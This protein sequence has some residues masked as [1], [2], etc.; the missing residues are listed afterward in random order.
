MAADSQQSISN[1]YVPISVFADGPLFLSPEEHPNGTWSEQHGNYNQWWAAYK[2]YNLNRKAGNVLVYPFKLNLVRPAVHI[3]AA[4][5]LGQYDENRIVK[6]GISNDIENETTRR[7]TTDLINLL[8]RI[9]NGDPTLVEQS[10]FQ[11]IFGGFFYHQVWAP[12]NKAM[13][14]RFY[15]LDPRA[16]FPVWDGYDYNRIISVDIMQQIPKSVA[17]S[18]YFAYQFGTEGETTNIHEHWDEYEYYIEIDGKIGTWPDGSKMSGPNPW[19]DPIT[20]R[21]IV[22]VTYAPRIRAGT[23]YGDS[24]VPSLLGPQDVIND[25]IAHLSEGLAD[26]MHQQPWIRNSPKGL[27]NVKSTS[28]TDWL[29]LGMSPFGG[30]P[31]EV[32]R[33]EGAKIDQSMVDMV[34]EE[35]LQL[36][37]EHIGAPNVAWGRTESSIRSALVLAFM[38]KPYADLGRIYR[39]NASVAIQA[40]NYH[41]LVMLHQK[42][43]FLPENLQVSSLALKAAYMH[44]RVKFAPILPQDRIDVV[45]E[46]VQRLGVNAISIERAVQR[47]DGDED[48]QEEIRRIQRQQQQGQQN[49]NQDVP[50]PSNRNKARGGRAERQ[51]DNRRSSR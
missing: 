27:Q 13:P 32:G 3:H 8:W 18:R 19:A 38:M 45:N 10:I 49:N 9:N 24:L 31:P 41:L 6:F 50:D 5:L 42:R 12:Q 44:Q 11:Q 33:L 51:Y 30:D 37:R 39:T 17:R 7:K 25:N 34:M 16:V 1:E 35:M 43:D 47:L 20:G 15:A 26:A 22:P 28:R 14:V 23:F 4:A 29:N 21:K 48:L 2:G 40:N 36:A 46:V